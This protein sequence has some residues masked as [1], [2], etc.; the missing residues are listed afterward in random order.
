M[1]KKEFIMK[2]ILCLA[3]ALI[4]CA[5]VFASCAQNKDKL[6]VVLLPDT[7]D[8]YLSTPLFSE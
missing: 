3:I 4:M 1:Y 5:C 7:G 2:K 8:R 6:I